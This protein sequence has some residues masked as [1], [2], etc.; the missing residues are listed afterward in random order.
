MSA[1][2]PKV[3]LP[4]Q[5][6]QVVTLGEAA[7]QPIQQAFIGTCTGGRQRPRR[8]RQRRARAQARIRF[9]VIPASQ[10]VLL[11]AIESG[12]LTDLIEAGATIT[13]PAAVRAWAITWVCPRPTRRPSAAAAAISRAHGHG[14]CADLPVKPYVVA[15]SA[16][17]GRVR[18]GRVSGREASCLGLRR[19]RQ[20]RC[21]LPRQV[22]LHPQGAGRSLPTR[23]KTSTRRLLQTCSRAT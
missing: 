15:A 11:Q 17:T 1:L 6:D 23:S 4:H 5:P 2:Q 19:Q 20:H 10:Q 18:S 9:V 22:H 3:A 21:D 14:G 13:T 12:V 16:L 8:R 7:G